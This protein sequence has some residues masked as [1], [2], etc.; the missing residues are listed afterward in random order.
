MSQD[1]GITSTT[2]PTLGV[3]TYLF[4]LAIGSLILAPISETYGRKPVYCIALFFFSIL[5]IPCAL[6]TN[7]TTII[8]VRLFGAMAG[9]ATIAS[10]PG[11][12]GDIVSDEYRALVFSVWSIGPMNGPVIGPILSA[13]ITQYSD[14][15]WATW[16]ILFW[17]A[18]AFIMMLSINETYAPALL[19]QKAKKR[20]KEHDDSR[21]WSRYDV[22]VGF[23]ELMRVNLSRPFVMAVKEPICIFWNTYI[24]IIYGILYLCFVAYPIVYTEKRGWSISDSSLAFVG[25]GVGNMVVICCAK[26][27]KMM[28]EAHKVD[29]RAGERLPESMMS[30]VCIAAVL[31]PIGQLWFAWTCLPASIHPAIPIAAGIPFGCGVGAVFI[32]ASSY[33]VHSYG[34]Y[35]ASAMAGNAVIRSVL[36][37]V[38]PLAGHPL[39]DKL[40]AHWAGTLLGLL[41]VAIMPVPFAFYRYGHKIREKSSLIREMREI[42]QRQEAKRRKAEARMNRQGEKQGM[43]EK[44]VPRIHVLDANE[45]ETEMELS[46]AEGLSTVRRKEEV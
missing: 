15:R 26:P 46:R 20:R 32:Y 37:G 38:L 3:T 11:T 18:A 16:L 4:G 28:I 33:L 19:Q 43:S 22:R 30:V 7:I 44:E 12:L 23:L 34:I 2:I 41:V 1:L 39:Y 13:F 5:V 24:G 25:I 35:A 10:A 8:V 42:E 29:P 36:G 31:I 9:S 45:V 17:G 6:A 14:W 21:Y 27:I 40:G